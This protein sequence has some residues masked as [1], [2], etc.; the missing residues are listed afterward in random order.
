MFFP[1]EL[2]VAEPSDFSHRIQQGKTY[3]L[4]AGEGKRVWQQ[5]LTLSA[6]MGAETV[7]D[8]YTPAVVMRRLGQGSFRVLV[9]D[10]YERQCAVTR[11]HSLPVLEVAHIRGYSEGGPHDVRN[12][13]ALR[14]DL[15]RL[16]D[17]HYLT[18]DEDLRLVV[19]KRLQEEWE[20]GREYYGMA[21]RRLHLPIEAAQRPA[22]EFLDWHR[23]QFVE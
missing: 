17:G 18:V 23:G 1:R 9:M 8:R 6:A 14:A 5:C 12:G 10:A 11:E 15:H 21:G 22:R 2:W 16:F 7:A 3:D 19:S 4:T 13:L 20:N